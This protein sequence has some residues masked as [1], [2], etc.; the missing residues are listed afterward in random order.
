M[1]IKNE[2]KL[3]CIVFIFVVL[4]FHFNNYFVFNITSSFSQ[5]S[6]D[7]NSNTQ[8]I[9]ISKRENLNISISLDPKVPIVDQNTKISFDIKKLNPSLPANLDNISGKIT[10]VD[11]DGRLFKFGNKNVTDNKFFVNYIFPSDG[12]NKIILQ[13]YKNKVPFTI[14]SFNLNISLP[15]PQNNDFFAN[16]FKGLWF[17]LL[18]QSAL[19]KIKIF[20]FILLIIDKN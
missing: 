15:K 14:G 13:L 3:I 20:I 1:Q 17:C 7:K 9:W 6:M 10:I 8:S 18:S 2:L 12:Q 4:L 19:I 11:S 5:N 16:L